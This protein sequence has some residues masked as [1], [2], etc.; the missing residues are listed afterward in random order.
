ML[1]LGDERWKKN[2]LFPAYIL[3]MKEETVTLHG[4]NPTGTTS[5]KC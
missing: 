4:K 1:K 2:R 5:L 3:T